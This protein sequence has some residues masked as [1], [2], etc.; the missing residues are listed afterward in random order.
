MLVITIFLKALYNF[1]IKKEEEKKKDFNT[2]RNILKKEIKEELKK[3]MKRDG[4]RRRK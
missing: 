3:E 4:S 2:I 1:C